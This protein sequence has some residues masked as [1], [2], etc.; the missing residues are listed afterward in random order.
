MFIARAEAAG[1]AHAS[2]GPPSEIDKYKAALLMAVR[3]KQV[4]LGVWVWVWV[5]VWVCVCGCARAYVGVGRRVEGCV[6]V[7]LFVCVCV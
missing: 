6:C 5:W 7:C 2:Q 1:A 3:E 4:C